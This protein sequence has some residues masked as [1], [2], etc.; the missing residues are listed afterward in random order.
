V[1]RGIPLQSLL[2]LP[3]EGLA[4][5][6]NSGLHS[7]KRDIEDLRDLFVTQILNIPKNYRRA[8]TGTQV[9]QCGLQQTVAL[10]IQHI[11]KRSV[12]GS[13]QNVAI[14]PG[15]L[16]PLQPNFLPAMPPVPPAVVVRL[17]DGDPVDPRL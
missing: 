7:T 3:A 8:K 10:P 6:Q 12:S 14:A 11:V 15:I 13:G 1:E 5:T 4:A 2:Q 17:V 9:S 16:V